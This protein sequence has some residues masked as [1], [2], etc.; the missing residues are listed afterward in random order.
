MDKKQEII[1][2]IKDWYSHSQIEFLTWTPRT[3]IS[4]IRNE[5]G[6][7][8]PSQNRKKF[9]KTTTTESTI[10]ELNIEEKITRN[11]NE[12]YHEVK[13]EWDQIKTKEQFFNLIEFDESKN[14]IL[15]YQCN[16]R[17]VVI[18]VSSTQTKLIDKREHFLRVK[19]L[20][21]IDS[22]SLCA[23]INAISSIT[24]PKKTKVIRQSQNMMV[25]ISDEHIG[26]N[27]EW[28]QFWYVYNEDVLK[29]KV[30]EMTANLDNLFDKIIL[31]FCWDWLDWRQWYT[32]R[33]GHKLP[34]NMSSP[35]A[36]Q[37]YVDFKLQIIKHLSQYCNNLI[38]RNVNNSNH[39]WDFESIANIAVG[40]VIDWN[41][42]N[43]ASYDKFLNHII[44]GKRCFIITHWKDK[45]DMKFWL[46]LNPND[47]VVNF[48]N[49]YILVH[50]LSDYK[51]TVIKWDLHQSSYH[52]TKYFDYHNFTTFAPPSSWVQANFGDTISWY[53]TLVFDDDSIGRV[54]YEIEYEKFL[55]TNDIL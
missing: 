9:S 51:I 24:L 3:A 34:Q 33:W 39:W 19:P 41:W 18:R 37:T 28:W 6:M 52:K 27:P 21:Q 25:V 16:K 20:V 45:A 26:M 53:S 35:K 43:Y 4:K 48:L 38:V 50:K 49:N 15:S 14:E 44:I 2:M 11:E 8:V 10:W 54:D 42:V 36:F 12:N 5:A 7:W 55:E 1:A 22:S 30:L 40:K 23:D 13:Y 47:K 32:T 31:V 29:E 17:Q 46:T